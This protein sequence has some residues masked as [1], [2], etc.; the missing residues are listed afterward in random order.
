[1]KA[2][3]GQCHLQIAVV[4]FKLQRLPCCEP[5]GLLLIKMKN[6]RHT[7]YRSQGSNAGGGMD[8]RH[9]S[10]VD[11]QSYT[12]ILVYIY[13]GNSGASPHGSSMLV[14]ASLY[15]V[16]HSASANT[17]VTF[18]NKVIILHMRKQNSTFKENNTRIQNKSLVKGIST[19]IM[20]WY[21][22]LRQT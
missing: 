19:G 21:G 6:P 22:I 8:G 3:R 20:P 7:P 12:R 11:T 4:F 10:I 17:S 5:Y 14:R 2:V 15:H 9:L 13:P 18:L 1:V 16:T